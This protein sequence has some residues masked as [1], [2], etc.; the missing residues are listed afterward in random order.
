MELNEIVHHIDDL[1][2]CMRM[3]E[4][5]F[6]YYTTLI[7]GVLTLVVT[8]HYMSWPKARLNQQWKRSGRMKNMWKII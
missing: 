5:N 1:Y 4:C 3:I 8:R 7:I 2:E 6:K